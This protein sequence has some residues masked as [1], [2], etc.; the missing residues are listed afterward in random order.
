M[1]VYKGIGCDVAKIGKNV[2]I[3]PS[4]QFFGNDIEIGDNVRID[5][6]SVLTGNVKIGSHIHLAAG[7]YLFGGAGIELEDFSQFAPGLL[8]MSTSDNF[9]GNSLVGPCIPDEYK[10]G[11]FK[12]KVVIKRHVILGART[13]VMPGVIIGEGAATGAHTLVM[14]DCLPWS[15]YVGSPARWIKKRSKYML[16]LERQYL[17]DYGLNQ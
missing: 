12:E 14:K 3:H 2:R 16:E 15:I 17:I 9:D 4:V 1:D 6:F 11:I 8:V 5:A 7:A 10:P 13:T